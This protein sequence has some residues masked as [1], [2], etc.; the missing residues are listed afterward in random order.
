MSKDPKIPLLVVYPRELKIYI[1]TNIC[2]KIFIAAL[3]I[4][5]RKWNNP[6]QLSIDE[7][8]N[9]M[10]YINTIKYYS[11]IRNEVPIHAIT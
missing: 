11:A 3:I 4:I 8:I 2:T 5:A 10:Q 7:Q 9:N 1:H 6:K